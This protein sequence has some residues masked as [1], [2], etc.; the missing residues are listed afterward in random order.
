MMNN[1]L[2][3]GL[4]TTAILSGC[5]I[6]PSSCDPSNHDVSLLDKMNCDYSGGYSAQVRQKEQELLDARTENAL[7]HQVYQDI[8][9][10]Q[11]TSRQDLLTQEHQQ[12]ALNQSLGQL[13]KQLK[14]R[15]AH[16][17]QIQ[18]QITSLEQELHRTQTKPAAS[19]DPQQLAVK[20]QQLL[21]LQQ[22]VNQLQFSLGYK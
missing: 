13:L 4:F 6:T 20:Q 11:T 19:A 21:S 14:G 15:N 12:A 22:K 9:A 10:Q 8:Q 2:F 3:A 5:A 18:Q 16:Q 7:F 17:G 1:R